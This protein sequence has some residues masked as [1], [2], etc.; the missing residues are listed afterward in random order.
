VHPLNKVRQGWAEAA[1]AMHEAGEDNLLDSETPTV[2]DE[3]E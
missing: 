2:F 3:K 1:K